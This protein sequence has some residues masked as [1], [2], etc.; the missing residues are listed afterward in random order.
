MKIIKNI[1]GALWALWVLIAFIVTLILFLIP[2]LLFCYFLPD[3]QRTKRMIVFSRVWMAVLLPMIGCPL[4]VKGR[5]NFAP[6]QEYVVVCNHNSFL[7]IFIATPAIPGANKTIAK[8]ELSRIPVFGLVY[9]AG[10]VLVDRKSDASRKE[11]MRKMKE[12]LDSGLHMCIYPEG[13]RNKTKEPLKSFQSGAFRLAIDTG[14]PI[15]PAVIFNTRKALP[16]DKTF[17]ARPHP[18]AM[19]FLPPV[20]ALENET[21][22]SL[23]HRV[24]EIMRDYYTKHQP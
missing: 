12:T 7:D 16:A 13:T 14:K 24:F 9:K 5:E 20:K 19:H 21:A 4:T 2:F 17:Y 15:I 3:P 6:G 22:A 11:S 10:S 1:L 18:L 8:I 23:Q